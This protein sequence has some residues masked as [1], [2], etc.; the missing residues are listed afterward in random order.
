MGV[1]CILI[2]EA[3]IQ[4]SNVA[5]LHHLPADKIWGVCLGETKKPFSHCGGSIETFVDELKGPDCGKLTQDA[6]V[7]KSV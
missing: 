6:K 1:G 4:I 7:E 3:S 2:L 5:R